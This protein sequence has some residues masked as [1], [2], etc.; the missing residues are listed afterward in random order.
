MKFPSFLPLIALLFAYLP[1]Q[2]QTYI[3]T[4]NTHPSPTAQLS[5]VAF[6]INAFGGAVLKT[7]DF[8][9]ARVGIVIA[10]FLPPG[11]LGSAA[12]VAG[13]FSG[14]ITFEED[15][16]LVPLDSPASITAPNY[17][18]DQITGL[19]GAVAAPPAACSQPVRIIAVDSGINQTLAEFPSSRIT[20]GTSWLPT[21][22][23]S[24]QPPLIFSCTSS[25]PNAWLDEADHGTKVLSASIGNTAGVLS[26]VSGISTIVESFKV[27]RPCAS[28]ALTSD[29]ISA[30]TKA[31]QD[32][33][34]RQLDGSLRNDGTI[35][36][37]PYRNP[38]GRSPALD[39]ILFKAWNSGVIV[40]VGTGNDSAPNEPPVATAMDLAATPPPCSSS[41]T[42][43]ASP[44]RI[45]SDVVGSDS[46][47]FVS[48]SNSVSSRWSGANWSQ[49]TDLFAPSETVHVRNASGNFVSTNGTSMATGYVAGALTW[50]VA[51]RPWVSP[52]EARA[53][54]MA[55]GVLPLPPTIA[56]STNTLRY[57]LD[58][59]RYTL[60]AEGCMTYANWRIAH[61]LPAAV[62]IADDFDHDSQADMIEFALGTN[63]R[64]SGGGA[65]L[66]VEN[67]Y[68][69]CPLG[70]YLRCD[71]SDVSV[72][73]QVSSDLLAW[74]DITSLLVIPSV[75][76][77][78]NDGIVRHIPISSLPGLPNG[79]RFCRVVVTIP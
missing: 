68:L 1:L 44:S 56:T 48:G 39:K 23:P 79:K 4:I 46:L 51:Q 27:H 38:C 63:P 70:F 54:L 52:A 53:W 42:F 75:G 65:G 5:Q 76:S 2:A 15:S 59:R 64:G 3:F 35:L 25:V 37:F 20:F 40:V 8:P 73:L 7:L 57:R 67:G 62:T 50:L 47:I 18:L 14:Q 36:T 6:E 74:T 71:P 55:P 43:P 32:E 30:L 26:R 9:D 77:Y 13:A 33:Y 28:A 19:A 11:S 49:Q 61:N 12:N 69:V 78:E 34:L 41:L 72:M 60:P 58:L 45:M 24:T 31:V 17:A 22:P 16:I 66:R 10:S 29:V 21:A